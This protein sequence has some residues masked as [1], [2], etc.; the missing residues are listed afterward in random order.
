MKDD[1]GGRGHCVLLHG[2]G[3]VGKSSIALEYA[4]KHRDD[5]D[6]LLWISA[7]SKIKVQH[8]VHDIS[9]RLG[10]TSDGDD[11]S[12]SSL[13]LMKVKSWLMSTGTAS[14]IFRLKH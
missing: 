12:E 10:L 2:L 5:Y 13:A 7:D 3:G 9:K 8:A 4:N 6:A 11:I 14:R 1:S